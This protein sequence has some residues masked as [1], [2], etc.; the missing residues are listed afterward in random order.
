[1]HWSK[2][3]ERARHDLT[4]SNLL[5]LDIGELPGGVGAVRLSGSNDE[6]YAPLVEAIATRYAV[7]PA[8]ICTAPGTSGA[9]FLA[10]AALLRP[11]DEVLVERPTYDPLPGAAR[12]LG[13]EIRR[14]ERAFEEGFQPDPGRVAAAVTSRTR[15]IALTNLHNPSGVLIPEATMR[16]IG[17]VAD[18]VGARVLVDEVY[19]ETAFDASP[20]PAT[21]ISDTFIST[22]SLTKAFGLAGLR[23]GWAIA[24]PSV[25]E[26][27]RRAR[28]VVDA[29]GSFPSE[30]LATVAFGRIDRLLE[31]AKEILVPNLRRLHETVERAPSLAWVSP[32]G[33]PGGFPR[34]L[35]T[36]D[37]GPF[38][39]FLEREFETS[40]AP[41]RF[42]EAPAHFR[43][44]IGGAP[45][46]VAR[47]LDALDRALAAWGDGQA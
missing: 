18:S 6:G 34:L 11:G 46:R 20:R 15:L 26:G 22:N 33:G 43:I 47:G 35:G 19:L 44:A 21:T 29:V 12:L 23:C 40:V 37:A 9:N 28:D 4:G 16:A 41:G 5:P 10:M 25:A 38:V 30:T 7:E 32:A 31:R 1:M 36:Q 17:E 27:M 14:F 3:H 45:D 42:F 2:T 8:R 39:E 13:A 24:S